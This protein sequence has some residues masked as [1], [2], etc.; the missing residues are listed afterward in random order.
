M[1]ILTILTMTA[2]AIFGVVGLFLNIGNSVGLP[3]NE[4]I[5]LSQIQTESVQ[6]IARNAQ[7][8]YNL[9]IST[10]V[11]AN[12]TI[13]TMS[14]PVLESCESSN[15]LVNIPPLLTLSNTRTLELLAYNASLSFAMIQQAITDVSILLTVLGNSLNNTGVTT[16]SSITL[17]GYPLYFFKVT[18]K[19]IPIS[20]PNVNTLRFNLTDVVVYSSY[21]S[22]KAIY[23]DQTKKIDNAPT[24]VQFNQRIVNGTE[25]ILNS[26]ITFNVNDTVFILKDLTISF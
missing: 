7:N 24:F 13:D 19:Q 16:N 4:R 25:L 23:N 26:I 5:I 17:G 9:G 8:T 3:R 22:N 21:L 11:S 6:L 12:T 18:V 1:K 20:V 14:L 15:R 2:A 10:Q